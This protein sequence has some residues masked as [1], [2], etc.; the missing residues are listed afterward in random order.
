MKDIRVSKCLRHVGRLVRGSV[1]HVPRCALQVVLS[2][3]HARS[4]DHGRSN[5]V[6]RNALLAELVAE[7]LRK[8]LYTSFGRRV[9]TA[10]DAGAASRDGGYI[11]DPA[12][13]LLE[14]VRYGELGYDE[15]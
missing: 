5:I 11:Y 12:P 15:A 13:L 14:H 4:R 1:L 3:Y 10:V 6:E 8:T 2:W 9:V 7:I